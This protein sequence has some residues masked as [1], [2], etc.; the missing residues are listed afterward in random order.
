[1][2]R[3][4]EWHREW[5]SGVAEELI[6]NPAPGN[7]ARLESYGKI[8][9]DR[10]RRE[11]R[12]AARRDHSQER[13][14]SRRRSNRTSA[15]QSSS[16]SASFLIVSLGVLYLALAQHSTS[17]ALERQHSIAG[18]LQAALGVGWQA[19]P[20][21]TV[22]TA[23]VSATS[24]AEV[25][26]DLFAAWQLDD[27]RGAIMI[28]DMSGKGVDAVVNT[29][30][31]KY[32]I[33]ALL[34]TYG[35][36]DRVMT[37]FNRLFASTVSD[38]SMFAVAFLGVLDAGAD[39]STYVCAGGEPA[40]IRHGEIAAI[41]DV[42][43]P[44]VGMASDSVYVESTITLSAGDIILLATD[45][46]T[47]SRD[48]SGDLLGSEGAADLIARAPNEPQALCDSLIETVRQRSA[49]R[50]RRRSGV[51][52]V[53]IRRYPRSGGQTR[54]LRR[55]QPTVIARRIIPCLD[56]KDGRVV[57]GVRFVDL[58]DAGDPVALARAY[59]EAGADELVF[60]DITATV[61]GR[62]ATRSVVAAVAA[63]LTIP[64][65]VG[66]G[67]NGID[68][69]RD[70]VAQRLRQDLDE[71]RRG[72][73][74]RP[75]RRSRGRIRQSVRRRRDRCA[76]ERRFWEVVVDGGRT[77]AGRD[78]VEW[79]REAARRGAGEILLTSMDAD[80]TRAGY[81]L[82]LTSAVHDA[83]DVPVIASGGAGTVQDFVDVF[84][85][86]QPTRRW[87]HRCSITR[88]SIS[89]CSKRELDRRTA[90]TFVRPA[91]VRNER[92]RTSRSTTSR[93]VPVVIVD[94]RTNTLLTLAYANREAVEKTIATKQTHLWSR[95]RK[96][97][98]R[99]GEESG[100]HARRRRDRRRLRRRCADVSRH[101]ARSGVSH[102]RRLVLSRSVF[103]GVRATRTPAPS[104]AQSI[105]SSVRSHRGAAR[106]L[107]KLRRKAVRGRRRSHRKEDRRGSD[108]ARDRGEEQRRTTKSSGKRPI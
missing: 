44:I 71:Q 96:R 31:C 108:R 54:T 83:V 62:R 102:R 37:E 94:A 76:P 49:R 61:E 64:F 29:A 46:L 85:R 26:G 88:F 57:K 60:L 103:A 3:I 4:L 24:E 86:A 55:S 59:E 74:S 22:G 38:P 45:G 9:D 35:R 14:K 97:L 69:A 87:P 92:R 27:D 7:V 51:A 33:R 93:L 66:G 40:F 84:E 100:Q 12:G 99:K 21:S 17:A 77:P 101:S 36:P 11:A 104:C 89:A 106:T 67:I 63:E 98:W 78:A 56:I 39:A 32:S 48:A 34:Q 18:H 73:Q 23:Y 5:R 80:G 28:A 90:C 10:I 70:L 25:G 13:S 65:A 30:F 8:L 42:G 52:C 50:S 41:L 20:G 107:A 105:I 75:D 6:R 72:A 15:G 1:M 47:E 81:D 79:A 2:A 16:R 91:A 95:S 58:V 53:A 68:D 19:I 43:G 82:P